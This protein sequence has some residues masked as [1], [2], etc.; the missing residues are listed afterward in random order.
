MIV[1]LMALIGL[2]KAQ[3][4]LLLLPWISG[5]L[6]GVVVGP[7]GF[8]SAGQYEEEDEVEDEDDVMINPPK[9][10]PQ[11]TFSLM[12]SPEAREVE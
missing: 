12:V 5:P 6:P 11:R 1:G 8:P 10:P 3:A 2:A 9:S 7:L 4:Q